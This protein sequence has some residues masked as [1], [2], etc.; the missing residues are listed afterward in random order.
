MHETERVAYIQQ[1]EPKD[2]EGDLSALYD[3]L[4]KLAGGVPNIVKLASLKPAAAA[5]AQELYQSVLCHESEL[6]MA[7]K[8]MVATVVSVING[9]VYCYEHHGAALTDLTRDEALT[10]A[11]IADYREAP[12]DDRARALLDF[13][14]KLTSRS[15]EMSEGDVVALRDRG[16]SDVAVS[17]LVQLVAYFNYTTRV[18]TGLGVDPESL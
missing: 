12:V 7:E 3:R 1:I 9:C 18:A 6:T 14:E 5:A 13:T 4:E 10:A 17:D 16:L 8:E 2:A 11:I 15:P